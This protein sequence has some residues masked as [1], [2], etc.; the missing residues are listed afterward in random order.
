MRLPARADGKPEYQIGDAEDGRDLVPGRAISARC[1]ASRIALGSQ[2]Q[3]PRREQRQL[4]LQRFDPSVLI[5]SAKCPNL[6]QARP[7]T[8]SNEEKIRR[9][10]SRIAECRAEAKNQNQEGRNS[11]ESIIESYQ[12]L[13][14]LAERR[15]QK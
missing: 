9:W 3:L 4:E 6:L 12:R 10:R 7:M 13:I 2:L 15:D 1:R 8:E 14:A 5:C 11:I